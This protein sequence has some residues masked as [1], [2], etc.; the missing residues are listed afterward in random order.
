MIDTQ[1][2]ATFKA[3]E[4]LGLS[5]RRM[6]DGQPCAVRL[7]RSRRRPV[8][9]DH[10]RRNQHATAQPR[11]ACVL[12]RFAV[13]PPCAACGASMPCAVPSACPCAPRAP[14]PSAARPVPSA[15][16]PVP[17]AARPVRRAVGLSLC[18]A[19]SCT[20]CGAA[21]APSLGFDLDRQRATARRPASDG[22]RR[23]DRSRRRPLP[24]DHD[25]QRATV[26]PCAV[27]RSW[28][29]RNRAQP[30]RRVNRS[31]RPLPDDRRATRRNRA[32]SVRFDH[33]RQRAAVVVN[34]SACQRVKCR[35]KSAQGKNHC[36]NPKKQNQ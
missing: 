26:Q 18:A 22:R 4:P 15:A 8:R 16:R 20:V 5:V 17:S 12:R 31:A 3:C 35:C 33:D 2:C 27:V 24:F 34:L 25:K 28:A 11:A 9:F 29:T 30:S 7:D 6:I 13:S 23:L 32:P 21:C 14:V 36:T 1:P 19:R 10:D